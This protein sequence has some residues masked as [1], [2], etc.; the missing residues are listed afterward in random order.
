[1]CMHYCAPK[2]DYVSRLPLTLTSYNI[3]ARTH[4]GQA[5][6]NLLRAVGKRRILRLLHARRSINM[7]SATRQLPK[8][9]P[10]VSGYGKD[11]VCNWMA[12]IVAVI[13]ILLLL[14]TAQPGGLAWLATTEQERLRFSA[15][16]FPRETDANGVTTWNMEPAPERPPPQDDTSRAS[17]N[18]TRLY[19]S[20]LESFNLYRSEYTTALSII[21]ASIKEEDQKIIAGKSV[22]F[23]QLTLPEIITRLREKFAI[24]TPTLIDDL[25]AITLVELHNPEDIINHMARFENAYGQLALCSQAPSEFNQVAALIKSIKSCSGFDLTVSLYETAFPAVHQRTLAE[26]ITR[27]TLCFNNKK[28]LPATAK[29]GGFAASATSQVA[30]ELAALK[31]EIQQLRAFAAGQRNLVPNLDAA[32]GSTKRDASGATKDKPRLAKLPEGV[33]YCYS[34]GENRTH[35]SKDCKRMCQ[36]HQDHV[37]KHRGSHPGRHTPGGR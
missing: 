17:E 33:F 30:D 37:N 1:M 8:L 36:A 27:L 2:Y 21:S 32:A 18:R 23:T 12:W 28:H 10:F 31:S 20:K 24:A 16:D 15:D 14:N 5:S 3:G 29:Q 13:N 26:L 9:M 22:F 35:E 25:T 19:K 11:E 7:S 4:R 6:P 34:C